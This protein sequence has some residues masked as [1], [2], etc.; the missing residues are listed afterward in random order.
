MPTGHNT[1]ASKVR[2][3]DHDLRSPA[4]EVYMMPELT[5]TT[6][7]SAAKLAEAGYASTFGNDNV[8]VYDTQNTQSKVSRSAVLKG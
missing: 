3:L 6:L 2:L 7:V 5:E 4:R 8:N 1:P